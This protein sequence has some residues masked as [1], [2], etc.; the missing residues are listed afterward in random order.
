MNGKLFEILG[1]KT[2]KEITSFA[3]RVQ[4]SSELLTYYND[5]NILPSISELARI[6]NFT[7]IKRLEIKL[8]MGI[9]DYEVTQMLSKYAKEVAATIGSSSESYNVT[10]SLTPVFESSYGKLYH[11]DC[12][13]LMQTLEDNSVDLIFAD[14][15]FNLNKLYPSNMDD[16]LIHDEYI[17]W[18]EQWM[19]ECIRI[20]KPGGSFFLWNIPKWNTYFSA[21]LN[22]RL[23]FRHWIATDIKYSLP[24]QGR[25]Y[26]S[27]YSLL[28]Y[29]KGKKP[30]YFKADRLPMEI[31]PKC[32]SDL[33]DYG[34]YKDKM[35]PLGI[36]M[37]DVWYDIPPVRHSKYKKRKGA[38]ELSLKLL[39]RV[40]EMGSEPG[41]LVFDPFG[42]SG[43]TYVTAEL[44]G[45]NWIGVEI[46]PVEQIIDRLNYLDEEGKYL[47]LIRNKVNHLFSKSDIEERRKSGIWT[48]DSIKKLGRKDFSSMNLEI[49]D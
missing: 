16:N 43:S 25:L 27:H 15:P 4:I 5:E 45:R 3:Q 13:Q 20:L 7:Q 49:F 39:D 2:K 18:S 41:D 9:I 29:T 42:G 35:N 30:K 36:S 40:I 28:Y 19:Q 1:L 17:A 38:N 14:P 21:F 33:K 37:T 6:E 8:G 12:I 23:T 24:I 22:K 44:K 11:A 48:P 26:P 32:K 31:C 10:K 47:D 34:G 46:G